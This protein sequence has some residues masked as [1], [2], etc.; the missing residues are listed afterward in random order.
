MP[1]Q[2]QYDFY[3]ELRRNS[4]GRRVAS[5]LDMGVGAVFQHPQSFSLAV[6][7]KPDRAVGAASEHCCMD[8]NAPD[9][10]REALDYLKSNSAAPDHRG[11][12]DSTC[13]TGGCTRRAAS[14]DI[15]YR[16]I[17]HRDHIVLVRNNFALMVYASGTQGTAAGERCGGWRKVRTWGLLALKP[18][19]G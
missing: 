4:S 13:R 12:V 8:S 17:L 18:S 1:H 16:P 6:T 7:R 19:S 14:A 9:S 10:S 15:H 11:R 5:P 2:R 3:R